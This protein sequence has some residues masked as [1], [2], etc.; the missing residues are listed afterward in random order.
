MK[1][2][3]G[4]REAEMCRAVFLDRDGVINEKPEPNEYVRSIGEFRLL[5]NI[6]DWIRLFNALEFVVIVITNQRGV[7]RSLLRVQSVK[8]GTIYS[9]GYATVRT[10]DG[11][12]Q[13]LDDQ[14]DLVVD[15]RINRFS[16]LLP[17]SK[18]TQETVEAAGYEYLWLKRLVS[19]LAREAIPELEVINL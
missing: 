17:F 15:V 6:A 10:G 3:S 5:P 2:E 13:P 1:A 8:V 16:G 11:L 4:K 18:H 9:F 7:A 12:R 19:Q 14:V